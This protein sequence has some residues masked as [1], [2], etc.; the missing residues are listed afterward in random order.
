MFPFLVNVSGA[1]FV[2]MRLLCMTFLLRPAHRV[3][4]VHRVYCVHRVLCTR[5]DS[6]QASQLGAHRLPLTV[7][8]PRGSGWLPPPG[9]AQVGAA[10]WRRPT[11]IGQ[12]ANWLG[13][14]L[15]RPKAP[16]GH[17]G[18]CPFC[19]FLWKRD[20]TLGYLFLLCLVVPN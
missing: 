14:A 17:Q 11:N 18:S 13:G 10:A 20:R 2:C 8:V 16:W 5:V 7:S 12:G 9:V 1:S 15:Q 6:I 4:R 19:F 3:H